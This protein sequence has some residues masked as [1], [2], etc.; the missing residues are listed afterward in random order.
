M[1]NLCADISEEEIYT[2]LKCIGH[3]KA[4][5]IDGYNAFFFKHRWQIIK[6]DI[7]A[8]VQSFFS[9]CKLHKSVN[10]SLVSLVPKGH[11]PNTVKEY[12]PIA[13]CTV[14]YKIISKV[15]AKKIT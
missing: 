12:R 7:I 14:L 9:T 8:A 6:Q 4:P 11:S 1:I 2:R 15:L 13:C 10:Y 5:G 3:D